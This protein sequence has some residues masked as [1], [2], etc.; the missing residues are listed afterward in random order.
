MLNVD[1]MAE[2]QLDV[3]SNNPFHKKY[4]K[5]FKRNRIL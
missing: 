5:H 3:N 4:K 2:K 1:W